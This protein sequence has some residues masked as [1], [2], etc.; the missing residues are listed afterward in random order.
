MWLK[1]F[2]ILFVIGIIFLG[3][4][5]VNAFVGHDVGEIDGI[6]SGSI[7]LAGANC[8]FLNNY[9]TKTEYN[10]KIAE[11]TP[12]VISPGEEYPVIW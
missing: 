10:N 9:Y 6:C 4:V 11:Y 12:T 5:T 7:A 2:Y 3:I 1:L 8:D